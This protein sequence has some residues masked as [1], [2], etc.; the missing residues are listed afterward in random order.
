MLTTMTAAVAPVLAETTSSE[1]VNPWFI[2]IGTLALLVALMVGL[3][4]FGAGR[5]HS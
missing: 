4:M 2:G 3:L 1:G 5:D